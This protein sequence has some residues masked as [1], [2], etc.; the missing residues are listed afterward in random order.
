MD[1]I[2]VEILLPAADRS[3]DVFIPVQSPLGEVAAL[4][5]SALSALTRGYY[6]PD[7][8]AML[9]DADSGQ[10][11]E[12]GKNAAQLGIPNGKKLIIT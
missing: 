9:F 8:Q 11:L 4:A 5:A 1:K 10:A 12:A 2:L 3:F 6:L 7:G